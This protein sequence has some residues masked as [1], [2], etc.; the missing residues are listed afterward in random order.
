MTISCRPLAIGPRSGADF[1]RGCADVGRRLF[2]G[3]ADFGRVK[4][5]CGRGAVDFGVVN[6]DFGLVTADCGLVT[7]D[8]GRATADCGLIVNKGN[9][10]AK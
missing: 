3:F 6:A 9:R 5:D 1:K 2:S 4:A 7:A 10:T 8:F